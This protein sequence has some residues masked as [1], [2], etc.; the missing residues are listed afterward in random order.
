MTRSHTTR[1]DFLRTSA[2]AAVAGGLLPA[3]LGDL[4]YGAQNDAKQVPKLTVGAIGLGGR[5]TRVAENAAE[6]GNI[7][8]V[9]DV[10]KSHGEKASA[11]FERKYGA[12]T[13]IF[14]D[15]L[16]LLDRKDIA[17]VTIGTPDHWHT[18]I[19]ID[20]MRAGKDVYC[21]K[22][23]T[24]TIKEGQ[25]LIQVAKET[26][27]ILQVG[28]QQRSEMGPD[29]NWYFLRAVATVRSGRL[30]KLKKVTVSLPLST[31]VGGPFETKPVPESLNWDYW[32]GQAPKVEYCPERCH[33][34]FRWWYEYSGGIGTDWGAHHL[35]ITQWALDMG[36]SGP[37]TID[38][39]ATVMP[40]IAGGYNTPKELR[41]SLIYPGDVLVEVT[42][43]DEGI[44]FEGDQ[45][46]M[47]V[48]RG[49]IT[50]AP[51]EEQDKDRSL[52][53]SIHK[54]MSELYHGKK[55]GNHMRNFFECVAS[56]EQPVSDVVS[57]HRS[58][59]VCH[60]VNISAR[61]RRKLTWDAKAE[62]FVGDDAA[63]DMLT[64]QQ[65]SPY[66]IVV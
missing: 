43:G 54:L 13:E 49:R 15:Y 18:K 14:D 61:L 41:S 36:N 28:T 24:L 29:G 58:V 27:K 53:D 10:D 9:C 42:T 48:N 6:L 39:T 55:P 16:K 19:C 63:N 32:L 40:N 46:R 52:Q 3:W 51:I 37:Q 17:A 22:P 66:E 30:G 21:E 62:Q 4:A 11:L 1:R 26:G 31:Q 5:G 12:K 59:S 45:G 44:L 2:G 47:Y 60:L 33:F 64:R 25:Q 23:L 20:A 8:A 50:G 56:R 7:V 65:R 34:T 35:D 57:Q 38:S